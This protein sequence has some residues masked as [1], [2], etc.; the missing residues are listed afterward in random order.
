M[1]VQQFRTPKINKKKKYTKKSNGFE[2]TGGNGALWCT[3]AHW[4]KYASFKQ[5]PIVT[6]IKEAEILGEAL[7]SYRIPHHF[8]QKAQG[9][10]S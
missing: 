8:E 10:V 5:T 1:Q 6:V 4:C 9:L 3:Q 2:M 7:V